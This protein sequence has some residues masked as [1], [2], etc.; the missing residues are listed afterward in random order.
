LDRSK[1]GDADV[2][3][4]HI[5]SLKDVITLNLTPNPEFR[6][7]EQNGTGDQ[8]H[9]TVHAKEK[10]VTVM[11]G[12]ETVVKAQFICPITRREMNG[13]HRF[14]FS[15]RCG[16]VVSEQAIKKIEERQ[17]LVVSLERL[18]AYI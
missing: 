1:Y 15:R 8:K 16:C 17:C 3:C 14:V 6:L 10:Q 13:Q 2:I 5:R 9:S 7:D 12:D 4:A 11:G 18:C